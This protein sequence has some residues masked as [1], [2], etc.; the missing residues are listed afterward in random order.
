MG[1]WLLVVIFLFQVFRPSESSMIKLNDG[2]YEDIVIAIHP[3]LPEN[4]EIIQKIKDMVNEA[5]S[6]LFTATQK[7]LFIRSAKILIPLTWSKGN[8]TKR[9]TETYDKADVVVANPYLKYGD[10]PYTLQYGNCGEPARYIHFTPNF[11]L[12]NTLLS[13]YGPRGRVFVHEWAH[14]RWGVY[15]EYNFEKPYYVSTDLKLEATRCSRDIRGTNVKITDQCQGNVCI[16]RSCSHDPNTG[17]YE[18]GCIFVPER[19]QPVKQSIMYM[20]ALPDVSEFCNSSNHNIEAPTL[21]NRMCNSRST[22]DVISSSRDINSTQPRQ[23]NSIPVPSISII[24]FKDRVVTLVL[25]VS[26][27]MSGTRI[28]KLYQAAE[29]FVM[30]IIEAGSY[31][32][33]VTFS[34]NAYIIS[35][36]LQIQSDT[37]RQK[38]KSLLPKTTIS[39]TNICPGILTGIGVNK[40]LDSSSYGTE[41]ILLSDGEDNYSPDRCFPEIYQSGVII[42]FIN[43]GPNWVKSLKQVIDNTGGSQYSASESLDANGL[44]D[45]FSGI[46]AG[47]G[48]ITQQ[49]IQLESTASVLKPQDCLNGSV[50]IDNTVGN[51]T[52]FVVTWQTTVP[53]IKLQDPKGYIYTQAFFTSDSTTKSS[54]LAI[55][56][57]AE[58]GQWD[59]SICNLITSNQALGLIVNSRAADV[60]LPPITVNT[61]MNTVTNTYPNPMIVYAAVSQGMLPVRGAKVT[62]II[63]PASGATETLELLDN[64]AGADIVKN[65][66]VYSRYFTA[67]KINGRYNLKVRVQ[68]VKGQTRLA[69]HRSRAFYVPGYVDNGVVTLNAPR[70]EVDDG[71]LNLGEFSR[72]ASGGAF[73]VYNIPTKIPIDIYKPDKI[74]DLD[75]TIKNGAITLTWTAT[76][77]DLDQGNAT[78][79]D[80]RMNPN[81]KDLRD[82]FNGST[83]INVS[84][85]TPLP[86]GSTETFTFVPEN[87]KLTN[88][89]ILFFSLVAIDDSFQRSDIS[90]IAQAALFIPPTPIPTPKLTSPTT[91][92]PD[93]GRIGSAAD[94]TISR[95]NL[96]VEMNE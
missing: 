6:Y 13:V 23:N 22:W 84:S 14:L 48:D 18:E 80:L 91:P 55:P 86:A 64:G 31:V 87:I 94:I 57:T 42:H 81:P 61:H 54:R 69:M 72:I 9:K 56:G 44:I 82:N 76:G 58:R 90:N 89:T 1:F 92:E 78:S 36:L 96:E 20:Q 46:S 10:D 68:G 95:E 62:A 71:N 35:S 25:D 32:G 59:Y 74:I 37:D 51:D 77:D 28:A 41:I 17:L 73:D 50:I 16:L 40:G 60:N 75:A 38:L 33:I 8:Y 19:N 67:Y 65:D 27:S 11:L 21:Q 45:A 79:Y 43:L 12:D 29:I 4:A 7:R 49:S 88:G 47:N 3:G 15:D 83:A 85:L 52:F 70:P 26:G 24:Q 2:G 5:T 53:S 39:G 66:G 93:S 63:E 34:D 30:Q